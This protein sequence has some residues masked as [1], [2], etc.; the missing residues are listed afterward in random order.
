MSNIAIAINHSLVGAGGWEE[1]VSG[2]NPR[3]R[4]KRSCA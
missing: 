2:S 1:L 4:L 3:P